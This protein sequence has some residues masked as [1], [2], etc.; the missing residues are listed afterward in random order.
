MAGRD[1]VK[2]RVDREAEREAREGHCSDFSFS[3]DERGPLQ[4]LKTWSDLHVN[5]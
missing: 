4:G 5:L 2:R 1:Q 3:S